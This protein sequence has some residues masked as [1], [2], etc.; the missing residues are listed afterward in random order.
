MAFSDRQKATALAVVK[1]FET[2]KP[3]GD[4]TAVA[5]LPDGAGISY[6]FSQFTHRSKSLL[7]VCN[8]YLA[9]GGTVGAEVIKEALPDLNNT[10]TI[11]KRSKDAKLKKALAAAGA[12]QEMREAQREIAWEFYLSPAIK[13]CEGSD[14]KST[15]ALAVVYDSFNQGGFAAVRNKVAPAPEMAWLPAFCRARRAWLKTRRNEIVHDT[16]YRPNFFLTEMERGNWNLTPPLMVHGHRVTETHIQALMEDL[17]QDQPKQIQDIKPSISPANDNPADTGTQEEGAGNSASSAGEGVGTQ[18]A[19]T[20][21]NN[22]AAGNPATET[23]EV[24]APAK[25]G[26]TA[27]ATRATILGFAVPV[28]VA[29]AAKGLGDLVTQGY[30][31]AKEVGAMVVGLVKDNFSTVLLLVALIILLLLVKKAFR[32]ITLLFQ[33]WFAAQPDKNDVVVKPQ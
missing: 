23:K 12:T 31:D 15:M 8:R 11:A 19:E 3:L 24:P 17:V 21:V 2:S 29:A 5:V 22:G 4:Y 30:I 7:K 25:D 18:I 32:Q 20:I 27:Q 28:G 6:G 9:K 33:M 16:V 26:A 1:I 13:A 14:F 10:K